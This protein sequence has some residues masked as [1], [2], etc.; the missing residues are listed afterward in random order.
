[1]QD[2]FRT[3]AATQKING[4]KKICVG[5]DGNTIKFEFENR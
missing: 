1:M 3:F 2:M 5:I 4:Y